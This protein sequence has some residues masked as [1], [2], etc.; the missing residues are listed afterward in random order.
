MRALLAAHPRSGGT[1]DFPGHGSLVGISVLYSL[2]SSIRT[3]IFRQQS[4][5]VEEIPVM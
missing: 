4:Q 2:H 3:A 1:S 5:A